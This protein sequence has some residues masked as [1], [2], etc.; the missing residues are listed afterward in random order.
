M[1]SRLHHTT[2][3]F[4]LIWAVH[5][6]PFFLMARQLFIHHYLPCHILSAMVAG[7][8]FHFFVSETVNGPLTLPNLS[9]SKL[10]K[11]TKPE[12]GSWHMI[13]LCVFLAMLI[14]MF[15]FMSPMTYGTPGLTGEQIN[16]RRFL[17]SWTY[18]FMAKV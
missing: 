14:G 3:F 6:L 18:H 17:S 13:V 15:I 2:G 8:I 10:I 9:R 1:S 5:Y 4:M 7:S 16:M 12:A 11:I